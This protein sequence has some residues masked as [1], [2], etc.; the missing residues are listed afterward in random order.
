MTAWIK[1]L[2]GRAIQ[3][4]DSN[5][6][7]KIYASGGACED[8]KYLASRVSS[9]GLIHSIKYTYKRADLFRK[10]NSRVLEIQLEDAHRIRKL[11]EV[12]EEAFQNPDSLKL[13]NVDVLPEQQYFYEKDLFPLAYVEVDADQDGEI[14]R[15]NVLDN[16]SS[17]T[18]ETPK[19]KTLRLA[20]E[21]SDLVPKMD[22]KLLSI[23]LYSADN[24]D[25]V[26]REI[27]KIEHPSE[28]DILRKA[29]K[30]IEKFDPD[31]IIT[32]NG[33]SFVL[34]FLYSKASKF[35]VDLSK[36]NR[37]NFGASSYSNA[38]NQR[39]GGKTYFSYG[40]ILYRPTTHRLFGRLHL[41]EQNTF[42]YDQCMLEGLFEV[43]R[44]CRIPIHT[45][46]RASIGKCLSSLQFYYASKDDILIS[47]KPDIVEDFKNG[48]ELFNADRGGLVLKPLPGVHEHVG[49][50]D[51]A[52]LYPSII[53][54]YNISAETVNC[55]CCSEG[56]RYQI[57]ELKMHVC[58]KQKGIVARSLAL[59]LSKRFEYKRLRDSTKDK[60][61]KKIYNERAGALKW[62][63][64]CC[65]AK[66]SPVLIKQNGI[67]QYVKIGSFI[68]SIVGEKEG[69]KDC[70][71]DVFVAGIDHDFK[72]KF[73][74]IKKLLKVPNR[75]KLLNIIMDDGR[76]VIATRNHPFYL[77][78]N[79]NLEVRQASELEEGNFIPVAKKLPPTEKNEKFFH[80]IEDTEQASLGDLGFI[81]VRKIEELDRIDEYVYCFEL[82]DD[83]VPGFFTG[84]G[85]VFTHN[86][87]GYLSYRNAKFGK[88]DS[89]IAVCALARK[90][91]LEA[92]HTSEYN[93]FRVVHGIV[94]S[95]WLSKKNA[96]LSDYQ[97]LQ[98]KIENDTKFKIAIEGIYKWI[99]FLPSKTYSGKQVANRYFGAFE[100]T[101]ELKVRGIELRRHDAP[102]YF[103]KCQGEI[104][105]ELA[106]CDNEKELR[107][108]ARWKC[109]EIFEKY[110]QDLEKH[111][112][113]STQ[114]IITRRLS[115]NLN[116][117]TSPRQLSVNAASHLANQGLTLKAGQSVSYVITR[118]KSSGIDRSL[119]EELLGVEGQ[120]YDSQ[121][122]IELLAD[123]CATVLYPLGVTKEE[124][125]TRSQS[126]LSWED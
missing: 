90:T 95:L 87:F 44:L 13:Y 34:P 31:L 26:E 68:N 113:P 82:A 72:N 7:A 50:L 71:D 4:K 53:R 119:P 108:C 75:Q 74:K 18:Y 100:T 29:I 24:N 3:L 89:H 123:C 38:S 64:V 80:Q 93:G 62:I 126:L 1:T 103:K 92:T 35:S 20:I 106:K 124:L 86:C 120:E 78:K 84:D 70:P 49:E 54:N 28:Q 16:V 65:L 83:E 11:A 104:L 45:S 99:V 37:D 115:K 47:W 125:L 21:I 2:D 17:Y 30:E 42:V 58:D 33:D 67:V 102:I 105:N 98:T 9:Y 94:D 8:P 122:Y 48:Y 66:E 46:M 57:E 111:K 60:R 118:Y 117:Y 121:R 6:R 52:S 27:A 23:V 73:C 25:E 55:S 40:R 22:S 91:L 43:S 109:V 19:L 51:F 39:S 110:A 59:P 56:S 5:W 88:I 32:Q 41:D 79:E 81:K 12:L 76:R 77:L 10:R 69:I 101:G 36:L 14:R 112:V 107:H 63:L 116:E 85:A 97:E 61:L 114:L 15:W 96:T